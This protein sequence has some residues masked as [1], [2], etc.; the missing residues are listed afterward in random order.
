MPRNVIN[1]IHSQT[2]STCVTHALSSEEARRTCMKPPKPSS[3]EGVYTNMYL[4][5]AEI[6]TNGDLQSTSRRIS[7]NFRKAR[8]SNIS[9]TKLQL[10]FNYQTFHIKDRANVKS[11]NATLENSQPFEILFFTTTR[12][13][14]TTAQWGNDN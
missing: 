10:D 6:S 11:I 8:A 4:F 13:R 12:T 9:K 1:Q 2:F 7:S 14:A 3:T 5:Q